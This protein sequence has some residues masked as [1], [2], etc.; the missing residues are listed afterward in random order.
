MMVGEENP[1]Y[2]ETVGKTYLRLFKNLFLYHSESQALLFLKTKR[3]R[4]YKAIESEAFPLT[5]P[6]GCAVI[7]QNSSADIQLG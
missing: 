7:Q 1:L 2:G 5:P 4:T 6:K 3:I